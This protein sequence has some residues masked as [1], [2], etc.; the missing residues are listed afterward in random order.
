MAP[1]LLLAA[2]AA[3][4]ADAR[5]LSLSL[6]ERPVMK[7]VRLL[8]D[9]KAELE[10]E[11]EEDEAVYESLDCWCKQNDREK[12]KAIALGEAKIEDLQ[13]AMG[14]YAAKIEEIREGLASTK[15]KLRKDK[16][17]LDA[18]TAMRMQEAQA[19]HGEETDLLQ[20]VQA[21]KQALVVLGRHNPS[22]TQL[23]TVAKSLEALKAMQMAKDSLGKDK[24][25]V[26]K[27][28]FQQAEDMGSSSV[29]RKIPGFQSY[30]PQSGQIFGILRQM[31]EDFE[32]DLSH[33]QKAELKAIEDYKG[34]KQAKEAEIEAGR[35]QQTQLEQEDAE[36]REKN[37]QAYEEFLDTQ[38]QVKT[39]KTFLANLQKR[40][41]ETDKEYEAR[42][43]SRLEEIV[44]VQDTIAYLSSDDAFENF[45]K[46]MNTPSSFL[47]TRRSSALKKGEQVLRLRAAQA[48]RRTGSAQ[49]EVLAQAVQLDAFEKVKAAIDAMVVELGK[50][51]QE[52]I[53]H[54]DWCI[55]ETNKNNRSLAAAEDKKADLESEISDLTKTIEGLTKSIKEKKA[56]IAEMQVEMK[57]ASE[58]REAENADFQQMVMD[59][60]ITQAILTKALDRMKEVYADNIYALDQ[61]PGAPHIQTSSNHT[62]PGNGPARFDKYE[63]SASG[64]KVLSMLTEV[65]SDAKKMENEGRFAEQDAQNAYESFMKDSNG[66]IQTYYRAVVNMSEEKAKSEQALQAAGSDLKGTNREIENLH[67]V[68]GDL[69]M[70][71]DFVVGNF[72][73][74]QEARSAEIEALKEAKAILSGMK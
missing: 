69:H 55:D 2:V 62:D 44:A 74:R 51:Q 68:L 24:L 22:L 7:V 1:L 25:A 10:K 35:K 72:D 33:A 63:K 8:Q 28:F 58:I 42:T 37:V 9:M 12:S 66:S 11:K 43:K 31:Q 30:T 48:L 64:N 52:E 39:D 21:I 13:A 54:R 57:K 16:E 18:A 3:G 4:L 40:C 65:L 41:A 20:T 5:S 45:D 36:F 38:A 14:E 60:Q 59:Q 23:R 26:L 29:L 73:A 15:E 61:Q 32:G 47:Q 49:L 56:D 27:A 70:S 19:F 50:Q 53:Q 17:A 71:C 6:K 67:G 46:T 34:L